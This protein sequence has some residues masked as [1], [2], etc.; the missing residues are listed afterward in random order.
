MK[1]TRSFSVSLPPEAVRAYLIDFAHAEQWDPGTRSCVR[2]DSGP[3]QVGARWHN[4]SQFLGRSVEL[5]YTL[6]RA[7]SDRLVFAGV[8]DASTSR[9][10]LRIVPDAGG[11]RITYSATI[12]LRSRFRAVLE[13]LMKLPMRRI[14]DHTV[15]RLS[16]TLNGLL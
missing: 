13:P 10:D 6:I 14:A 7:D 16:T 15:E 5:T 9:D 8:N 3:V 11:S 2:I 12:T 1:V 4:V